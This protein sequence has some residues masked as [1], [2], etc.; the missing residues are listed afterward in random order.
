MFQRSLESW[1]TQLLQHEYKIV[2]SHRRLFATAGYV[3]PNEYS[4]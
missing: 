4:K 2:F 3:D 1:R